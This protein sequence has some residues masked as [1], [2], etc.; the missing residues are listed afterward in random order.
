MELER[1]VSVVKIGGALLE[2]SSGLERFWDAV[3]QQ[4]RSSAVVVVHGGGPQLTEMARRLGHEPRIVQG[5]R[6]TTD[7]DLD[8]LH[9]TVRGALNTRLVASAVARGIHAV[10]LS[11]VDGPTLLV[12]K[13]PPWKLQG[14]E[15]DFGWVGDV[16]S[17]DGSLL[18]S[19]IEAGFVPVVAPVAVDAAG[20]T[21]NVN[22][23]T[24]AVSIARALKTSQFFLVTESGGVLQDPERP[25][26]LL[27]RIDPGTFSDGTS[28]GWIG[29]GMLVKLRVA[30]DAVSS[31]IEEVYIVPPEG[32]VDHSRG[33]RVVG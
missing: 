22:A 24:V 4:S 20:Q 26:S 13:R 19:L 15:V 8:I 25:E 9:W 11:G 30:F 16:K 29:G 21:Y 6:V 33:T 17:V 12:E 5:R 18:L 27:Q 23:D 2:D 10:G 31:G 14:E 7:L 32:L 3:E 1:P 28:D